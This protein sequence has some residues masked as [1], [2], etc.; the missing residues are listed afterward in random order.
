M[1][2]LIVIIVFLVSIFGIITIVFQ[3]IPVLVEMPEVAEGQ[4]KE[5]LIFKLK[6]KC[7]N[8]PLI[9]DICSGI[10]LQKALSKLS[11]LTLKIESKTSNWLQKLRIKSQTEKEKV[12]DNYWTEVKKE[13]KND[14]QSPAADNEQKKA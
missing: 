10:I 3:K 4:K 5:N 14:S 13:V 2:E 11:V 1:I 7:K 9:K 12:N 6:E 8:L